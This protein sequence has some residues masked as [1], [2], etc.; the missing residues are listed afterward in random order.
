MIGRKRCCS[1][2]SFLCFGHSLKLTAVVHRY[3]FA[4]LSTLRTVRLDLLHHIHAF[5][6]RSEHYVLAVEPRGLHRGQEELGT[7]RVGT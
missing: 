7:V 2:C 5:D 3:L 4:R 1:D 6:H